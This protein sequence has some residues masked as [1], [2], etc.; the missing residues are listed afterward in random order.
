LRSPERILRVLEG[1][2]PDK[3]PFFDFLYN[4]TSL[5]RFAAGRRLTP[6][7]KMKIWRSLGFDLVC[8]GL[9]SDE[10]SRVKWLSSDVYTD[11]W[12]IKRKVGEGMSW[13]L[14][15]S[16]KSREDLDSLEVPA[17][18][19]ESS[20][21]T[22]R[23]ALARYKDDVACSVSVSGVFTQVWS[24]MGFADFVRA[25]F[26]DRALIEDLLELVNR[27]LIEA[28]H[29]CIDTG[30]EFIWIADDYGGSNG[31]MISPKHFG[32]LILP[33]L[34][35]MVREFKKRGAWVLLHCDG[36]VN[37]LMDDIVRTE[38]DA[39][40]PVERKAGMSLAGMKRRYGERITLIGNLE[41]S[42]LIPFGSWGEID[43]GIRDCFS[44]GAPGGGYVFASDH[45]I[46]PAISAE[47]ARFVY[48]RA[49]RYRDYPR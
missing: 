3:V 36:N 32:E 39:F 2:E 44:D 41:A 4:A 31:P 22:L 24:M 10:S 42:R 33:C 9:D 27:Y 25:L 43:A 16:V 47:R 15:G 34:E 21:K 23:W 12:G 38:I 46:H 1:G 5:E 35:R 17:L 11:E 13:Y 20:T 14:D 7:V 49:G 48:E 45:S 6:E 26:A 37:S 18:D 30:A 29:A 28:G 40:H 8:L 19:P